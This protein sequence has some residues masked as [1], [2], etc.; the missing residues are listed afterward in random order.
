MG[1]TLLRFSCLSVKDT[2]CSFTFWSHSITTAVSF[3]YRSLKLLTKYPAHHLCVS[4]GKDETSCKGTNTCSVYKLS[5]NYLVKSPI[6]RYQNLHKGTANFMLLLLFA[7][8]SW[9]M[10][11]TVQNTILVIMGENTLNVSGEQLKG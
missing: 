9:E 7:M 2:N 4:H 6:V 8:V 1:V 3:I 5:V 10:S 11:E